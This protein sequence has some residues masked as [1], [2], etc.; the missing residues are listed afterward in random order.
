MGER[1]PG[2]GSQDLADEVAQLKV[3][4]NCL[5][6]LHALPAPLP[7]ATLDELVATRKTQLRAAFY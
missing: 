6:E 4:F 3:D 7:T 2:T 1:G 5:Q